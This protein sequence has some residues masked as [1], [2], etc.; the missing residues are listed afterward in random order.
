MAGSAK[1]SSTCTTQCH[2]HRVHL[3]LILVRNSHQRILISGTPVH[4]GLASRGGTP[5][6]LERGTAKWAQSGCQ[7]RT[8]S[9]KTNDASSAQMKQETLEATKNAQ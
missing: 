1:G 2:R 9:I 4:P 3:G 8:Q 6:L 7:R 5:G